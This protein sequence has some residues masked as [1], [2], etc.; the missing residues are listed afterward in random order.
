MININ[1]FMKLLKLTWIRR[2]LIK[3]SGWSDIFTETTQCKITP[4]FQYGA[5]YPRQKVHSTKNTRWK[6]TL[7]YF[8]EF[9]N[10]VHHKNT[11]T[12]LELLWYSDKIQIQN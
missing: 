9:I 6:E 3:N 2:L 10:I 4:L 11:Q 7:L 1:T 5:D 8:A 12:L